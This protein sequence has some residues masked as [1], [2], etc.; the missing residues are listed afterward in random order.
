MSAGAANLLRVSRGAAL[1]SL[2]AVI[3]A[4]GALRVVEPEGGLGAAAAMGFALGL[5]P[6][7]PGALARGWRNVGVAIVRSGLPVAL[8]SVAAVPLLD[9]FVGP[10]IAPLPFHA[11]ALAAIAVAA[12]LQDGCGRRIGVLVGVE[13]LKLRRGRLLKAG[14]VVAVLGT[15]LTAWTY[16][17]LKADC[18][19][20]IAAH[21][22][23]AGFW[24]AEILLIVLGATMIAGELGQGTMKM[25]LPHAYHRPEWVAAK[26]IVL[27]AAAALFLLAVTATGLLHA[28]AAHGLGDG[29]KVK[30]AGFDTPAT[31]K[32]HR[33]AAELGGYL[34]SFVLAAGGSLAASAL[35]GLLLS[36]LFDTLVPALSAAFLLFV[37]LKMGDL[38]LGFSPA[39][40]EAIYAQ[41]PDDLRELTIK[42][43][44][45]YDRTWNEGLLDVGLHLSLLTGGLALLASMRLFGR[46]DLH[47]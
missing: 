5:L 14:L 33:T 47:G 32:V 24:T 3:W 1:W 7:L 34:K 28:A 37:A 21:S 15:L 45:G 35:L 4:H 23:R 39:V 25:V 30:A 22:L 29:V 8:L 10:E 43:G 12:L 42:I 9:L 44:Q 46:R 20:T 19:W 40:L 38:L 27:V 17:P 11:I 18:G 26:T 2:A 36:C 31:E 6:A 41:V 13:W 16:E